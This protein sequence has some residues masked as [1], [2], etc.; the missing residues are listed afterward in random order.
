M[1]QYVVYFPEG[2]S[3]NRKRYYITLHYIT[4]HY[5]TLHYITLLYITPHHIASHRIAS[6][7]ITSHHITSHHTTLHY[8]TLSS[9][10]TPLTPKVTS[11][12]STITCYTKYSP[13]AQHAGY[14]ATQQVG[15][16]QK[17]SGVASP[18]KVGV[19]TIFCC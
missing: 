13:P 19:R 4:L 2:I 5:I 14:I 1:R 3:T 16:D 17:G 6:H 12:A 10:Q 9:F 8:I 11:G 7:H 18:K 15:Y